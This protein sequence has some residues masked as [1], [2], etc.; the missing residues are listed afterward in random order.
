M[1]RWLP[2]LIVLFAT[3]GLQNRALP[4]F[5]DPAG[6]QPA[7]ASTPLSA[8][9]KLRSIAFAYPFPGR[10]H[11][12]LHYWFENDKGTMF[13]VNRAATEVGRFT[14]HVRNNVGGGYLTAF[15][16]KPAGGVRLTPGSSYLMR[17]ETYVVPADFE[18]TAGDAARRLV[19]LFSRSETEQVGGAVEALAKLERISKQT[20]SN[21][22][23]LLWDADDTTPGQIGNYAVNQ[24]GGPTGAE[25]VLRKR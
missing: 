15:E 17:D 1:T 23:K 4:M 21:G 24:D 16:V 18:F 13:S 14:L 25:I 5:Y 12:G 9:T 2:A 6:A 7:S 10:G 19:I 8:T 11:V 3:T 22:L 20:G